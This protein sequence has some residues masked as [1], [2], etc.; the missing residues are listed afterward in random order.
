MSYPGVFIVESLN[1]EDEDEKLFEGMILSNILHLNNKKS[2]YY[3]IRTRKELEEVINKFYT[4][5]YRYLHFSCHGSKDSMATTLD[6]I[7]FEELAEI[8]RPRLKER[9]L[10]V[11]ACSMT[12]ENLAKLII[13]GSS[14]LSIIGPKT[15]VPFNDSAIL[16]ASFYH[17]MF[18]TNPK[19]MKRKDILRN[20][21]GIVNIF[22]VT[23]NYYSISKNDKRGYKFREISPKE[24]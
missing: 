24:L 21:Q 5:Q 9:R 13:P 16:W 22:K 12:N 15:R 17:L 8:L 6:K 23:L 14:C 19:A 1:F 2:V 20:I 4:S 3:Y 11:S 18:T 7:T 10:F